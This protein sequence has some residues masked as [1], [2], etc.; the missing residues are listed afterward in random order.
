MMSLPDY[1]GHLTTPSWGQIR[2]TGRNKRLLRAG[3]SSGCPACQG[4]GWTGGPVAG[5][6]CVCLNARLPKKR[7]AV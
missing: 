5:L 6:P 4:R 2:L 1:H 3:A 7:S